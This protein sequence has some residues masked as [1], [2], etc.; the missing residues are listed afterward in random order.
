MLFRSN[1]VENFDF[2]DTY[3]ITNLDW[4]N[5][6]LADGKNIQKTENVFKTNQVLE[7][8]NTIKSITNYDE[9]TP[10]KEGTFPGRCAEL[11][12]RN[13][14]LMLFTVNVVSPSEYQQ[15]IS[16]LKGAMA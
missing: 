2:T 10:T 16:K 14:S 4:D 12:G 3:P 13:Q 1:I 11:F 5:S 8:S 7:Y 6:Y 15:Q 9:V